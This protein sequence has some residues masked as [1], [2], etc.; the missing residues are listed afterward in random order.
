[1]SLRYCTFIFFLTARHSWL[2]QEKSSGSGSGK[3]FADFEFIVQSSSFSD[4]F[5]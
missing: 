4:N 2:T 5:R 3:I 1:M